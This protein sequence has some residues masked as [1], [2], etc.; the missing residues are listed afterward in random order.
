MFW[1]HRAERPAMSN[2]E[3]A[4]DPL[5]TLFSDVRRGVAGASERLFVV[6]Y[7]ELRK[8][9]HARMRAE[10]PGQTLQTTALVNEA[11]LRLCRDKGARWEN[12][13]H[14]FGAAARS[15]RQ[16]LVD[17]ARERLAQKRD[18]ALRQVTLD[19]GIATTE[20]SVDLIALDEA[21]ERLSRSDP[22]AAEVVKLRYFLGL[23]V[24]ETAD[25]LEVSP[26]TVDDDWQ[27]AKAWLRKEMSAR[28]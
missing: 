14:F 6:V 20:P 26:R 18:G 2:D 12:R 1:G 23:T 7:D 5:E 15:M 27:Y 8:L 19:E 24:E 9:A 11:Y 21:L 4:D 25:V 13:R 10:Q 22:R 16:I 28:E 3:P 17:R